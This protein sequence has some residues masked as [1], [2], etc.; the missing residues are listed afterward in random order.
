MPK[1]L[2]EIAIE[3][4]LVTKVNVAKAGKISDEKKQPLVVSLI[5][6]LG[7]DEVALLGAM[8]KQ[9]RVALIDPALISIDPEALRLVSR[10]ACA[11]LRVLPLS[12]RVEGRHTVLRIAMADPTDTSAIAELEQLTKHE[13]DVA[14][15]PL[16]AI[17][18]LVDR[19]YKQNSTQVVHRTGS[20]FI[21]SKG[22]IPS[23]P[24]SVETDAE[25]SVTAQIPIAAL[26]RAVG[27]D[28]LEARLTALV[29]VLTAKGLITE[30][31]LAAALQKPTS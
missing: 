4:G 29:T 23:R 3:A 12:V 13:I 27:T 7:V 24:G 17:D 18:E 11:R 15:L 26:Q 5:K 31:E 14:A 2:A 16:S 8:R 1:T 9:T 30:A 28:D 19:G 10:E 6:D 20:M 21:T 25:V 22:S